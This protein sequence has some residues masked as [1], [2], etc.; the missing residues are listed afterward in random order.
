M[1]LLNFLRGVRPTTG[2][3]GALNYGRQKSD[4]SHDHRSNKGADRTPAQKS[5]DAKR[6]ASR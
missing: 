2:L 1:T 6:A 3:H 4:G 5:A